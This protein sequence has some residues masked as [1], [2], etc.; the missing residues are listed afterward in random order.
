MHSVLA[1]YNLIGQGVKLTPF[2]SGLINHTWKVEDM[3]KEYILQRINNEVFK[4]PGDIENN[5]KK[6]GTHLQENCR[7][8]NFAAPVKTLSGHE[9]M[10]SEEEGYFRMFP[11]ISL[12]IVILMNV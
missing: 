8:Y 7:E 6:I 11:F 12:E 2:G 5:I 4:Q 1:A 9:M 10:Y 3:G